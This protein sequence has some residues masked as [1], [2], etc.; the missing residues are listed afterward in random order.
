MSVR[1]KMD[2]TS[3]ESGMQCE[4]EARGEKHGGKEMREPALSDVTL[5]FQCG[6]MR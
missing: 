4:A 3:T 1:R 2:W 5:D 6:R